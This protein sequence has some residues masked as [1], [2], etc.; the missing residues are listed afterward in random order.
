MIC[1]SPY[2]IFI[3]VIFLGVLLSITIHHTHLHYHKRIFEKGAAFA[4]LA[5]VGTALTDFLVGVS[6]QSGK[7]KT[8]PNSW[9]GSGCRRHYCLIVGHCQCITS[10]TSWTL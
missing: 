3:A 5:A 6:S 9:C 4:G 8:T 1:P 2:L 7:I 10:D